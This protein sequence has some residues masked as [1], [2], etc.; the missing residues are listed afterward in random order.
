M[1]G[2]LNRIAALSLAAMMLAAVGCSDDDSSSKAD[3]STAES[4]AAES[5]SEDSSESKPAVEHVKQSSDTLYVKKQ[6][7]LKDDFIMGADI[8]SIISLEESG[9]K[10]YDYDG[11]EADIFDTLKASGINYIRVRIWNDP[12][13]KDGNGYGGGNCDIETA[14]KIGKRAADAGLK[15]LADFHY[16][17]FWADPSKQM[18]PKAWE[19]MDI[20]QKKEALYKYTKECMQKLNDA[21]ADVGMVQLGNE[22]NGMMSGEKIWMNI[23]YLMDAGSRAVRETNPDALL[24]VHF[25]N[26]ESVDRIMNYASKLDY[27]SLDYDVFSSSY[28][29]Y[30][31]GTL[32]NLTSV[33]SDISNKY[34]KKVMVAETSWAYTLEDGDGSSNNIGDEVTYEKRYPFTVQGQSREI[35]DVI[36]AVNNVGDAGIGVFYWEP[37]WIPVPGDSWEE[38]SELWEKNGAGWASS[39]SVEYDP[40]DAGKYYGGSSWENQALFD[41][42]GK[43]LESLKTFALVYSGNEITPVPDAI[44]DSE[45]IVKLGEKVELPAKVN[46]IYTDGSEKEIDVEW[47]KADLEAMSAGE[48]AQYTV[49]G[50]ADGMETVCRIS[51]V[52][53][54]Y[55]LNYSFEDPDT[56][57][58]NLVNID[59]KTTELTFQQKQMDAVTGE[60]SVHFW[61]E[62]G[63]SFDLSQVVKD[64]P[65]GKYSLMASVQGG[66]E[67]ADETQD[68]YIYAK[69]GDKEYKQAATI[70]GWVEWDTPKIPEIEIPEGAEVT[71]GIHV[72]AAAG[73]WGT[74]DDFL[75]NPL[76]EDT[77][78]EESKEEQK[79]EEPKKDD[80]PADNSG[81]TADA[82]K[83]SSFEDSDTSMWKLENIDGL[84]T[85]IDYQQKADDAHSGEFALH[86]WGENGTKFRAYQTVNAAAGRYD[87]TGFIQGGFS[88]EDDSQNIYFYVNVNG[89][90]YTCPASITG[91]AV[92]NQ[93]TVKGIEIPAGAD[94][95]VGIYVEAG[96]Q[97]WG[98]VDDIVLTPAG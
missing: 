11:K 78:K 81:A 57:M 58:W 55:V 97:S 73:S 16:S 6:S 39:Y 48:P 84:T 5:T 45:L 12:K 65:A 85:Q 87:L 34:G 60:Y 52:D 43:P 64:A 67:G 56:S 66:F 75:L 33:L 20:D 7:N 41:F 3:S 92:W 36:E 51:M 72:E 68:I 18:C 38:R 9:V 86:F 32:E 96:A 62:N 90:E 77:K 30:W 21:G 95:K 27:Y 40:E 83:N 35:A 8:S 42:S 22:T 17:D 19:G 24:A 93:G 13:D 74:V 61:G 25:T 70:K 46:A 2:I 28:Y 69:V 15:L 88:A 10:F 54:N 89:T 29:P 1:K 26:P 50:T 44:K 80:I 63:T 79:Q 47:E 98:T 76:K 94:V 4:S 31:H 71:V 14:C 37:A 23:Y 82:V 59:D 53:A 49:K 91:W